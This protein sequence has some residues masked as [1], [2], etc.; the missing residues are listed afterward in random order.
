[1]KRLVVAAVLLWSVGAVAEDQCTV[2]VY[3]PRGEFGHIRMGVVVDGVKLANIK[4]RQSTT[5][6]V[7]CGMRIFS[8][9]HD[10]SRVPFTFESGKEYWIRISRYGGGIGGSTGHYIELV[11]RERAQA[12]MNADAVRQGS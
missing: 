10:S 7:P 3:R 6:T 12:E 5:I 11:S 9:P 1:M 2:N 8:T 4:D